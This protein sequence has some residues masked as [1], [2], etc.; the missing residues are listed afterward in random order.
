MIENDERMK[1]RKEA[2]DFIIEA[3]SP[4]TSGQ[5]TNALGTN[6]HMANRI[7]N[8]FKDEGLI[9]PFIL[10]K[11]TENPITA[12]VSTQELKK[13]SEN[14]FVKIIKIDKPRDEKK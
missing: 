4:V 6:N 14:S 10:G 5:I 13:I 1:L 9:K 2:R 11:N 7:I 8:E 12:W 3:G